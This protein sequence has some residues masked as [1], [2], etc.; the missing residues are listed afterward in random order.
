[1]SCHSPMGSS[2]S[3]RFINDRACLFFEF[4][5]VKDWDISLPTLIQNFDS[6]KGSTFFKKS[7]FFFS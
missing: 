6:M 4:D 5:E 3:L 1:M 2:Y 7:I